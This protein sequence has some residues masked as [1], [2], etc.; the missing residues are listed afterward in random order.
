LGCLVVYRAPEILGGVRF[1]GV[2]PRATELLL[3]SEN[4]RAC[5]YVF[6]L[7]ERGRHIP[8]RARAE[9]QVVSRR[10]LRDRAAPRRRDHGWR[11]CGREIIVQRTLQSGSAGSAARDRLDC[12]GRYPEGCIQA[13]RSGSRPHPERSR[14]IVIAAALRIL[15]AQSPFPLG[16]RQILL[17]RVRPPLWQRGAVGRNQKVPWEK[18][19][20]LWP[21]RS[22]SARGNDDPFAVLPF[23][24]LDAA[25]ARNRGTGADDENA[26]VAALEK[27]PAM[28]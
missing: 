15:L 4:G 8:P 27:R 1:H 7:R 2:L 6:V 12:R 11:W 9:V 5:R 28:A 20:S 16:A 14:T 22:L 10:V 3:P 25:K 18:R 17:A 24:R 21:G 23:D 26:A 19:S 13:R